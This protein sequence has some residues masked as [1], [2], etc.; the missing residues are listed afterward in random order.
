MCN[1]VRKCVSF[2]RFPQFIVILPV[3][4]FAG[5]SRAKGPLPSHK[6]APERDSTTFIK[7]CYRLISREADDLSLR[8]HGRAERRQERRFPGPMRAAGRSRTRG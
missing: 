6:K 8:V 2:H 4:R 5:D 1:C 3:K 7:S